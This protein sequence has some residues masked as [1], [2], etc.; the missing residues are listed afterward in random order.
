[1]SEPRFAALAAELEAELEEIEALGGE[2]ERAAGRIAAEPDTLDLRAAGSVLHDFYSGLE[3]IFER[4][5]IELDG[6]TPTGVGWHAALLRRMSLPVES[7]RPAVLS[8]ET[9][10]HLDVYLRFRHVFRNVYGR[11]LQWSRMRPLLDDLPVALR[12]IGG[13]IRAFVAWLRRLAAEA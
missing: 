6:G 4:I 11:R 9:A 2:A 13:E 7:I 3:R 1:M 5:A 8:K 10:S 12:T